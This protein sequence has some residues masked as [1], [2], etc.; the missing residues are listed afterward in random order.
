MKDG[1]LGTSPLLLK[2]EVEFI[3]NKP[4]IVPIIGFV[5]YPSI[6]AVNM[7]AS[8]YWMLKYP[9]LITLN[10]GRRLKIEYWAL[11]VNAKSLFG[12]YFAYLEN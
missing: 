10:V 9:Y 12:W 5:K 2:I 6:D 8:G 3:A 11:K 4:E 1:I 7:F